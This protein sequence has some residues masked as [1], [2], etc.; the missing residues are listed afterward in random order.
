MLESFCQFDFL[1]ILS[2]T[3][4][5]KLQGCPSFFRQTAD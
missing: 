3:I 1:S 5:Y 4:I 2:N